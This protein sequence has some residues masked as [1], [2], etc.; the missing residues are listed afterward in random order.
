MTRNLG[1]VLMVVGI[2][3]LIVGI[4]A[5]QKTG[6]QVMSEITGHY[7]NQTTW[8]IFGGIALIIVGGIS[9]F[10]KRN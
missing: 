3:L 2:V 6:E 5:S 4:T 7:T 10:R 9:S 8:Y 1:F